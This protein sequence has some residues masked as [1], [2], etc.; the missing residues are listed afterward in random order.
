MNILR[1]YCL[2]KQESEIENKEFFCIHKA[3]E[4]TGTHN[5]PHKHTN[6]YQTNESFFH[7]TIYTNIP[8]GSF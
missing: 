3:R 4:H 6:V 7:M 8:K 5:T 1:K 2:P